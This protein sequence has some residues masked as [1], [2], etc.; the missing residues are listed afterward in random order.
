M[1]ALRETGWINFRMRAMLCSFATYHLWLDWRPVAHYLAC[2]FIDYEPGIHYPQIQ[3]QSGVTGINAIRIYNPEKQLMDQDPH[4]LFCEYW[5]GQNFQTRPKIINLESA[6]LEAKNKIFEARKKGQ[7]SA[8]LE[9]ILIKH[10]SR[11]YLEEKSK[12]Q[13]SQKDKKTDSGQIDLF[14]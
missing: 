5:L 11:K 4:G 12:K 9:R 14:D 13:K 2:L 6:A 3:M 1:K 10:G 8:D 7:T